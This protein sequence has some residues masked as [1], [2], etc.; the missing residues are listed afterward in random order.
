MY[1]LEI[2]G[3]AIAMTDADEAEAR[4]IFMSD[5]FKDDLRQFTSGGQPIWNGA[6]D[7]VVRPAN[8]DEEDL[9]DD[10]LDDEEDMDDEDDVDGT[11]VATEEDLED[12]DEDDFDDEGASIMFLV[13]IDQLDE[14]D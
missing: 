13:P 1:T 6:S 9:F 12:E 2:N 8:D 3:V 5:S 7:F 11:A 10:A 4:E 14:E